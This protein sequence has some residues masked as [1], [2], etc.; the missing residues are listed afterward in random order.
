MNNNVTLYT[1]S[2]TEIELALK[3]IMMRKANESNQSY[4]NSLDKY[5]IL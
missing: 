5:V 3:R 4:V 2:S 1:H